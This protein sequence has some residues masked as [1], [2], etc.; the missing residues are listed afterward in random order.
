MPHRTPI[1]VTIAF[2]E[3]LRSFYSKSSSPSTTNSSSRPKGSIGHRFLLK[4]THPCASRRDSVIDVSEE[5]LLVEHDGI[6]MPQADGCSSSKAAD[7]EDERAVKVAEAGAAAASDP[8]TAMP[9]FLK[10][11]HDGILLTHNNVRR[12]ILT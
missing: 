10:I 4:M 11:S 5:C 6:S 8:K 7:D 12:H 9:S 3:H 1:G 2:Q